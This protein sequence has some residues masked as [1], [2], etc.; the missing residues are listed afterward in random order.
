[1]NAPQSP[2][3][4]ELINKHRVSV[5]VPRIPASFLS[6]S[7]QPTHDRYALIPSILALHAGTG[8]AVKNMLSGDQNNP[9]PNSAP[10]DSTVPETAATG[11]TTANNL[12]SGSGPGTTGRTWLYNPT[13]RAS[14][15][16]WASC[17]LRLV[18]TQPQC[19]QR[20]TLLDGLRALGGYEY[21]W[22]WSGS[23]E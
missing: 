19:L 16:A 18:P 22:G 1:M 9:N 2:T 6:P 21:G 10:G 8:S 12:P 7:A 15:M 13:T 5:R 14:T 3:V 23:E 17:I 20:T 4:P 11:G